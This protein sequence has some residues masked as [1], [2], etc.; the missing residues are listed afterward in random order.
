MQL[1]YGLAEASVF[2]PRAERDWVRPKGGFESH[3]G[4][5]DVRAPLS[6]P[7]QAF[8]CLSISF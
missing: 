1:P 4:L 6:S 8:W 2:L 3:P 5:V 7:L